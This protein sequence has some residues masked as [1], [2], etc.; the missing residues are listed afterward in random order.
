VPWAVQ[1][2]FS[3]DQANMWVVALGWYGFLAIYPMLLAVVTI[4]GFIGVGSLGSS[5]V[6]TLHRFPVVGAEFTP[7]QGG[8]DL[9][10]SVFGLVI[11]LVGLLYG[12]Q[13]VTQTAQ[14]AMNRVWNV[15]QYARPGFLPRLGRSLAALTTLGVAFVVNAFAGSL[16][17]TSGRGLLVRVAI[18]AGQ[19]AVNV[20]LY[21]VTFRLLLAP[22]SE[23]G[24]GSLWPGAAVGAVGFT[25]LITIGSGLVEHQL[26]NESEV[27]GAFASVIGVVVFL[28]LLAKLSLYAAELNPVLARRLYPRA[29]PM[30]DPLAADRRN[31][32]D[33]AQ[34]QRRSPEERVVVRP[35]NGSDPGPPWSPA[36][37]R[38]AGAG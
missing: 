5:I 4:F 11:G 38:S 9:H 27:Y 12:A 17:T 26:R 25:A 35:A 31:V 2:K 30:T 8:S 28:L 32:D 13:G 6:N 20:A 1:Q 23:I 7:G 24:T 14:A 19:L 3:T 34:E 18:I 22:G 36:E 10:G 33:L 37:T 15:P 21:L 29:L 16:A